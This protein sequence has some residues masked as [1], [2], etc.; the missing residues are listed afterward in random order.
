MIQCNPVCAAAVFSE[1]L[2]VCVW[3]GYACVFKAVLSGGALLFLMTPGLLSKRTSVC[4][5]AGEGY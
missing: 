5:S 3:W 4:S 2:G 1:P